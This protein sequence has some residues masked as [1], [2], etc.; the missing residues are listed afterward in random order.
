VCVCFT[1][2]AQKEWN[3]LVEGSSNNTHTY[4]LMEFWNLYKSMWRTENIRGSVYTVKT[5]QM[6][7]FEYYYLWLL[8]THILESRKTQNR[9]IGGREVGHL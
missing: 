8:W 1:M 7:N 4:T 2:L 3:M 9:E 5:F 6:F